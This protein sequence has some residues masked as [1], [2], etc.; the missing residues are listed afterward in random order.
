MG[1]EII[2]LDIDYPG[3]FSLTG[4]IA[5]YLISQGRSPDEIHNKR[6]AVVVNI[7]PDNVTQEAFDSFHDDIF[8]LVNQGHRVKVFNKVEED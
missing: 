2:E 5:K 1:D 6:F 7:D 3:A 4:A 8:Y